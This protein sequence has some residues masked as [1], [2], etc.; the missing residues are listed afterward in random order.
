MDK[1][2]SSTQLIT[3]D[4]SLF[5]AIEQGDEQQI[6]HLLDRMVKAACENNMLMEW[7]INILE[8]HEI[9]LGD[10]MKEWVE[11]RFSYYNEILD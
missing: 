8:S 1:Q 7:M 5:E 3:L 2:E 6:L 9:R 11:L 4:P 10:A